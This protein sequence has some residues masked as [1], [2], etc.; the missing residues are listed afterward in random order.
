MQKMLYTKKSHKKNKPEQGCSDLLAVGDS[1]GIR[2]PVIGVRG[3]RTNHYT[4]EPRRFALLLYHM[5]SIF[6]TILN[7]FANKLL[8]K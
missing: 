8:K 2:T 3:Q 1:K 7:N 4:I 5:L 6:A